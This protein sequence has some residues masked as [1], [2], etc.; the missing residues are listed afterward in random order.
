[1]DSSI[2]VALVR[3]D[4]RRG[5]VAEALALIGEDLGRRVEADSEPV[6]IPCLNDRNG[7]GLSTHRDTLSAAADALLGAGARSI[8]IVGGAADRNQSD[9]QFARLGYRAELWGRPATFHNIDHSDGGPSFYT[10]RW[11][12]PQGEQTPVRVSA[13]AVGARCRITLAV[14]AVHGTFRVGLGLCNLVS[15]VHRDDRQLLGCSR[16]SVLSQLPA[17]SQ[18]AGI[19]EPCCG[20]LLRAWLGLRAVSGGMRLTGLDRRR[21]DQVEIATGHMIALADCLMPHAAVV[22]NFGASHMSSPRRGR[23]RAWGTV[24]AGTDPVAVDAVAAKVLGFE[25][26][27]IPL[28]RLAQDLG[29]GTIDLSAITIVGDELVP[30]RRVR[31]HPADYLLKLAGA[32]AQSPRSVRRP[33]FADLSS[34]LSTRPELRGTRDANRL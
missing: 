14:A 5:A 22:D 1:L 32:R 20:A 4:R 34:G 11:K 26:A 15:T 6:L 3:S 16:R 25:P 19:L 30:P 2:K 10:L 13:R 9:D 12:N 18:T 28:L 24:I 29:L 27:Q 23:R 33:H 8:A 17:L 7:A 31:R 21:L